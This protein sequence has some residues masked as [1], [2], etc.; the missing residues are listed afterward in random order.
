M[1]Q[2]RTQQQHVLIEQRGCE[3][4]ACRKGPWETMAYA[5]AYITLIKADQSA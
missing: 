4:M 1:R 2:N 5:T 3:H